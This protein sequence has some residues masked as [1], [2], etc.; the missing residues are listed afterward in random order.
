MGSQLFSNY[1]I[2]KIHYLEN[3]F[4]KIYHGEHNETKQKVSVFVFDKNDL[5]KY[6]DEKREKILSFLRKETD[7]LKKAKNQHKNFLKLIQ[8]LSEDTSKLAFITENVRYNI[9]T[10][11]KDSNNKDNKL[12][13]KLIINQILKVCNF[14]HNTY[15]ISHN[16]LNINNIF[17]TED[18]I[19]KISCF[20]ST[21][22]L[23]KEIEKVNKNLC[24]LTRNIK[25]FAPEMINEL[26]IY[27]SSDIFSLGLIFYY[28]LN[29][30]QDELINIID[31]KF[32]SYKKF[33]NEDNYNNLIRKN[34]NDEDFNFISN[35][36]NFSITERIKIEKTINLRFF[37]DKNNK[38]QILCF[39]NDLEDH[40]IKDTYEFLKELPNKLD[41]FSNEEI[42]KFILP[43]LFYSFKDDKLINPIVPSIFA[44]CDLNNINFQ[45]EIWPHF[46]LLFRMKTLPTAS[47]FIILKRMTFILEN[48]SHEEF[49]NECV[50]IIYKALDCGI[51]KIQEIIIEQIKIIYDVIDNE[52]F[53]DKIYIRLIQILCNTNEIGL[54]KK[55]F[56]QLKQLPKILSFEFINSKL[57]NDL[58]KILKNHKN[59]IICKELSDLYKLIIKDID[60]SNIKNKVIPNI[61]YILSEGEITEKIY[62]QNQELINN[63]MEKIKEKRQKEFIQIEEEEKE[64]KKNK[65]ERIES[66]ELLKNNFENNSRILIKSPN[67]ISKSTSYNS[68]F[69]GKFNDGSSLSSNSNNENDE[70]NKN[71]ELFSLKF[72]SEN[73]II[74]NRNNTVNIKGKSKFKTQNNLFES[75]INDDN[76]N[77][78]N[79]TL[80]K[81]KSIPKIE[82]I[83]SK[84]D[85]KKDNKKS[86]N[87]KSGWDNDEDDDNEMIKCDIN[88]I[89]NSKDENINKKIKFNQEI[90]NENNDIKE[91]KDN[92][93]IL[94]KK[95]NNEQKKSSL[96]KPLLLTKD[97]DKDKNKEKIITFKEK[98][99]EERAK[100]IDLD[101]LLDD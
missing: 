10:W 36:L 50:P 41:L 84:L 2:E 42:K 62:N 101:S 57:L 38:L 17:I 89:L 40:D 61:F 18:N 85:E 15:H 55:I 67:A 13:K 73:D 35:F 25:Y 75:L 23:E 45:N 69:S 60:K 83:N 47:L 59:Y 68:P 34:I 22:S 1:K 72:E 4:W 98:K 92:I 30:N 26:K 81:Q 9:K 24:Q 8:P 90:L 43:N 71:N 27:S 12:E 82:I 19:V 63:L 32:S 91:I 7:T 65:I 48:I 100:K 86:N 94:N 77:D 21:T 5:S 16:N 96:Q 97:K 80:K 53:I 39:L 58:E 99:M 93:E 56:Y 37:K 6:T 33:I 54:I 49:I 70:F 28:I 64:E 78:D 51:G 44:I 52:M 76:D 88:D 66:K 29:D 11:I 74:I 87:K 79:F 3:N 20:C 31:N 95:E 46:K 14:M